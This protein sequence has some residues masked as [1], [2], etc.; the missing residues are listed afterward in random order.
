MVYRD[1]L[2]SYANA[3]IPIK[4]METLTSIEKNPIKLCL[5]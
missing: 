2:Q 3:N 4:Y 5:V 1:I